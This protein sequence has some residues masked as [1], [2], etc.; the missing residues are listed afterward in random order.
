M[1]VNERQIA[2]GSQWMTAN[3]TVVVVTHTGRDTI[4]YVQPD[5]SEHGIDCNDFV[6]R[7]S[8]TVAE[9]VQAPG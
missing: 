4:S 6:S 1:Y 2:I 5:D 8:P 9:T 7:F 3:G